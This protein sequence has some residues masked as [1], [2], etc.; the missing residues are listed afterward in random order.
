MEWLGQN[1]ESVCQT[2]HSTCVIM[3]LYNTQ[4]S[5]TLFSSFYPELK[6]E[7]PGDA[8]GHLSGPLNISK[9]WITKE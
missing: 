4:L 7:I 1:G 5:T 8:F 2:L 9:C 6:Q 3:N